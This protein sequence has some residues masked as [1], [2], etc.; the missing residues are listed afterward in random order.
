MIGSP[1][2]YSLNGLIELKIVLHRAKLHGGHAIM[3]ATVLA[4]HHTILLYLFFTPNWV[5]SLCTQL[6]TNT[7]HPIGCMNHVPNWVPR[8]KI[9]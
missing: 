9:S 4:G 2:G 5:Q 7:L 1:V 3:A 6:G 8:S